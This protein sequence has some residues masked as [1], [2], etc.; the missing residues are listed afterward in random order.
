MQPA[1]KDAKMNSSPAIRA[2]AAS[3]RS[4]A[5][6]LRLAP[7]LRRLFQRVASMTD[8]KHPTADT[9]LERHTLGRWN[10][11]TELLLN[12]RLIGL[13]DKSFTVD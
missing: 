6:S 1:W 9:I 3:G 11:S 5:H 4:W 10:D 8:V 2:V 7:Q 13:H 12:D